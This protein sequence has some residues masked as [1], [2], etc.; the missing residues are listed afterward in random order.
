MYRTEAWHW[1]GGG[2]TLLAWLMWY[3]GQVELLW[4]LNATICFVVM[5]SCLCRFAVM[6]RAVTAWEWRE[7]Y[8]LI[9]FAAACSLMS[10]WLLDEKPGFTQILTW[11]AFLRLIEVN[12]DGWR[13]GVPDYA[14]SDSA[15]SRG[16]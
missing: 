10:P 7:R 16:Y 9:F 2:A 15:H 12:G 5:W 13:D 11:L 3:E 6:D 14:R 8:V 1:V 4:L